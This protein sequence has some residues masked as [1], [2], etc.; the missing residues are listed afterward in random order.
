MLLKRTRTGNKQTCNSYS[1]IPICFSLNLHTH[2]FSSDSNNLAGELPLEMAY[3]S[4]MESLELTD[5]RLTGPIP[6]AIGSLSKLAKLDLE[7]NELQGSLP[8]EIYNLGA[9]KFLWL[10]FNNIEGALSEHLLEQLTSL[11]EL[12]LTENRFKGTLPSSIGNLRNLSKF[13]NTNDRRLESN[14]HLLLF[15]CDCDDRVS[16][17]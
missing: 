14:R 13:T 8:D 7:R 5:N 1:F 2:T 11:E 10:S 12:W 17:F 4:Q 16:F 3:F 6:A 15:Q 9:L